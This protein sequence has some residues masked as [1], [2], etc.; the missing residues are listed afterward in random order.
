MSLPINKKL[1]A[2]LRSELGS[3][4]NNHGIFSMIDMDLGY[5]VTT[6]KYK[7]NLT[8]SNVSMRFINMLNTDVLNPLSLEVETIGS[9]ITHIDEYDYEPY[10]YLVIGVSEWIEMNEL[11]KEERD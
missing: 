4:L 6:Q 9:G 3:R 8:S 2:K 1:E 5:D 10:I 7:I 11:P